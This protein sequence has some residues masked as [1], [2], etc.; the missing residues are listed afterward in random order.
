MFGKYL[1]DSRLH[2][3]VYERLN[4]VIVAVVFLHRGW[5]QSRVIRE[6]WLPH[7]KMVEKVGLGFKVDG[8]DGPL[9]FQVIRTSRRSSGAGGFSLE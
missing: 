6:N 8:N 2:I 7:P 3:P 9:A 4:V 1:Q 5:Q